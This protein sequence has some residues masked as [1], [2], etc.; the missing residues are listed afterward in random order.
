[1]A[2]I[3]PLERDDL[4]Q[5]AQLARADVPG[6]SRDAGVLARNLIDHPWAREPSRSLVAIDDDA[7]LIGSI[8]A[9]VRR[10]RFQ[11]Q[12]LDAVCVSHLVV[13]S[14]HRGG[15]AGAL[16]VRQLLAGDQDLTF[17]DSATPEV[18]RIWRTF[19]AHLDHARTCDWMLVLRGGRWLREVSAVALS[20]RRSIGRGSVPVGVIPFH[21]AGRHL[22][23]RA[24]PQPLTEVT[25]EDVSVA[26]LNESLPAITGR[27]SLNVDY[28]E[29][30]LSYVFSYLASLGRDGQIIR[31]LVRQAGTPVGWYAYLAR[32]VISRVLHV[33]A[34]VRDAQAVVDE[35]VGD[36]RRRGTAVLSGRLEPHLHEAVR[37][38]DAA[39]GF[40][41]R[42]L[43]HAR[44]TEVLAAVRSSSSLMT[45]LDLID[46]GWW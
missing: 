18:V 6:W 7:G 28:D 4:E 30:Y 27:F 31:R 39:L 3:R 44:N 10:M 19:G 12:P 5:V 26:D 8:G 16:L 13:A 25:G 24:F 14:A 42:P 34:S 46:S 40:A 38:H 29:S 17:S 9:Q 32:P 21:A 2:T 20:R 45:E 11:G 15:A 41:Q 23:A 43:V 33:G 1:M 35:M 22:A 36:A 37:R